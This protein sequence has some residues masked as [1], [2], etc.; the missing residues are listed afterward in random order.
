MISTFCFDILKLK[1]KVEKFSPI[2]NSTVFGGRKIPRKPLRIFTRF[3]NFFQTF[4]TYLWWK[5]LKRIFHST[6]P[7]FYQIALAQ[8]FLGFSFYLSGFSPV[9][10]I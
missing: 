7:T 4:H 3:I 10:T 1:G 6:I 2:F 9:S 5:P 8:K